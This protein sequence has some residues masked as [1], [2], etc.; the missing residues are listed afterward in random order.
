MLTYLEKVRFVTIPFDT[1]DIIPFDTDQN[2][3][4]QLIAFWC[5]LQQ[6]SVYIFFIIIYFLV[7]HSDSINLLSVWFDC[8]NLKDCVVRTLSYDIIKKY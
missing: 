2:G 4:W 1:C 5:Y 7:T 6:L 3:R 8:H